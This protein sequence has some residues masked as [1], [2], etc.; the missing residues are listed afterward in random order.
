MIPRRAETAAVTGR[1]GQDQFGGVVPTNAECPAPLSGTAGPTQQ[2]VSLSPCAGGLV[3]GG[4]EGPSAAG[5]EPQPTDDGPRRLR[6][7]L[8][9]YLQVPGGTTWPGAD[10]LTVREVLLSYPHAAAAGLVPGRPELA[11]RHPELAG[12]LRAFFGG[13]QDGHSL[14]G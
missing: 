10:G 5:G 4:P 12:A 11:A 8:L 14:S 2:A 6:E 9:G 3:S 1:L 7:L 13:H